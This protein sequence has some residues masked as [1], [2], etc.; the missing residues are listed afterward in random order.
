MRNQLNVPTAALL[1]LLQAACAVAQIAVPR[2]HEIAGRFKWT[3][4][5]VGM[6]ICLSAVFVAAIGM[7]ISLYFNS[8]RRNSQTAQD[9]SEK[10]LREGCAKCELTEEEAGALRAL[11]VFVPQRETEAHHLLDNQLLFERALEAHVTRLLRAGASQVQDDLLRSLRRKLGYSVLPSDVP[12]AS[13]R[14]IA[15]GQTVAVSVPGQGL[16]PR[17][18]QVIRV[19]EFS[20]T[21]K[22]IDGMNNETVIPP[23]TQLMLSFLRHGDG[24]YGVPVTVTATDTGR[25]TVL[26]TLRFTRN[27]NRK[28]IRLEASMPMVYRVVEYSDPEKTPTADVVKVRTVD[29]S[30]GGLCFLADT[31]LQMGDQILITLQIPGYSMGGIKGKIVK[32]VGL[33]TSTGVRHKHLTQFID[34]DAQ[35]RERIVKYIFEKQR[36][37]LQ[38]R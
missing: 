6:I 22:L 37:I 12:L 33:D 32:V 20:M 11:A 14:N 34:I 5:S 9:A 26:H 10:M 2:G 18:G 15:A 30:G 16:H 24:G 38:M 3:S 36:E 31:P 35:Q 27:Q 8:R 23:G 13:T 4:P 25:F 21:V 19:S 17:G 29:I 28:H 7:L 1:V